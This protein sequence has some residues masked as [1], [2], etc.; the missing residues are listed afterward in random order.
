MTEDVPER[1]GLRSWPQSGG[2]LEAIY[3]IL[4]MNVA[5][6][7]SDFCAKFNARGIASRQGRHSSPS[8]VLE[9]QGV[10]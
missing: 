5:L 1:P 9:A 7:R 10:V 2:L 6:F 3:R 8:F 4:I